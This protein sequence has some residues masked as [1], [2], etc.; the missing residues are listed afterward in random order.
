[1]FPS[2]I[3]VYQAAGDAAD[4]FFSTSNVCAVL[5]LIISIVTP[6]AT[7]HFS[8]R[9]SVKETF[10]MREVLIPQFSDVLFDFIKVSPEK[11]STS[12]S[13]GDFYNNYALD[14]INA[15]R[16]SS[17]ILGVSSK[18][19]ND[20][21]NSN[22]EDFEDDI[23]SINDTSDRDAYVLLL[24]DFARKAVSSIQKAQFGS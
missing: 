5:A 6:V 23:M 4:S 7:N 11:F 18:E 21:L 2:Y 24:G 1:M 17:R 13:L 19:L 14:I 3:Y 22:I 20:N 8:K 16:D 12:T 15:L 10:W 9:S